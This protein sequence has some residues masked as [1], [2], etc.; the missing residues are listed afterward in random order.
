MYLQNT[1]L[2]TKPIKFYYK[3]IIIVDIFPSI[4]I[5]TLPQELAPSIKLKTNI[6]AWLYIS[7]F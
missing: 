4:N 2:N 1:K 7:L 6:L 5:L 3:R